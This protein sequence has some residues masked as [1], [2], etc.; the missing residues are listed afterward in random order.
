MRT[1]RLW[2]V[3]AFLVSTVIGCGGGKGESQGPRVVVLTA[4]TTATPPVTSA[5]HT[6]AAPAELAVT[7]TR[8]ARPARAQV[9][10]ITVNTRGTV[11]LGEHS[12]LTATATYDDGTTQDITSTAQWTSSNPL[13]IAIQSGTQALKRSDTGP[14]GAPQASASQLGVATVTATIAGVTGGSKVV[15]L[16][17]PRF[18]FVANMLNDSVSQYTV[19]ADT[20][21]FRPN[22]YAYTVTNAFTNC[23]TVHP[24]GKFGYAVNFWPQGGQNGAQPSVSL[25]GIGADGTLAKTG[26]PLTVAA[27]PG[28]VTLTPSGDFAYIASS[29]SNSISAYAVDP[30]TGALSALQVGP[31]S[32]TTTP[33]NVVIEPAGKHLYV[34]TDS[35]INAFDIDSTTGTLTPI[36]GS[37][38]FG[39]SNGNLIAFE[40]S[41][42]YA[43]VTNPNAADITAFLVDPATGALQAIKDSSQSSGG[44]NPQ[45]PVFDRTGQFLYVPNMLAG[46]GSN[47]GNIAAFRIDSATGMLSKVTGS[48]FAAGEVPRG[49]AIDVDG[50]GKYL[51]VTDGNNLVRTY[52]IDPVTGAL[53]YMDR[54]ATRLGVASIALLCGPAPALHQPNL[55]WVLSKDEGLVTTFAFDATSVLKPLSTY[56]VAAGATSLAVE[57][58]GDWAYV[59]NPARDILYSYTVDVGG[60]LTSFYAFVL[61]G[62]GPDYVVADGS[63]TGVYLTDP[64]V[65]SIAGFSHVVAGQ[66]N[67]FSLAGLEVG[68]IPAGTAPSLLHVAPNNSYLYAYNSGDGTV[69]RYQL[70][71]GLGYPTLVTWGTQPSP[72]ALA[73]GLIGWAFE[74]RGKYLYAHT[75]TSLLGFSVDDFNAGLLV[76]IAGFPVITL[77]QAGAI[78]ADV[79]GGRIYAADAAGVHVYAIAAMNGTLTE[80][81][82][83]MPAG[84]APKSMVVDP[85]G[86]WLLV[87]DSAAGVQPFAI[88]PGTGKLTAY[89]AIAAGNSPVSIATDSGKIH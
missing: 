44:I 7:L 21:M 55:A 83:P 8:P 51:Y 48:P 70:S 37:P 30:Q 36:T 56:S 50:M 4:N 74:A 57:R 81:G 9:R 6:G 3:L 18:A 82:S 69:S 31:W 13:V 77:D 64:L 60:A 32:L 45:R 49:A 72:T 2:F 43:Y 61:T 54:V 23:F 17:Y 65:N 85:S 26:T 47:D 42:T 53:T 38:F 71:P 40:P 73:T 28:C 75:A 78:A 10:S 14:A 25:F 22:G 20:G 59:A 67:P 12:A 63:G 5:A 16:G 79:D 15:V 87:V 62:R 41:G 33:F 29:D 58:K 76:P 66:V 84:T 46:Y 88:E 35:D 1:V 24:S 19:N 34:G 27:K 68:N 89:P 86:A 80:I 11:I 52:T 39:F